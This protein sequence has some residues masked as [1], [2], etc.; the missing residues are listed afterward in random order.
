VLGYR[1]DEQ[2]FQ[3]LAEAGNFSLEK[4]VW[5]YTSTPP[6]HLHGMVLIKKSTGTT[7]PFT[8]T[9]IIQHLVLE[10]KLTVRCREI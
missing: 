3:F 9:F 6:I 1:L 8:F 7:L 4:N 2:G 10:V 5:S